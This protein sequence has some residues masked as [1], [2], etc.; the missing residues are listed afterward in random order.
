MK[1]YLRKRSILPDMITWLWALLWFM[2][3]VSKRGTTVVLWLL[4]L[5]VII[6]AIIQKPQI[7]RKQSITGLL[8]LILFLWH[9]NSLLFDP[10]FEEVKAS[11]V[12]KLSLIV[13]PVI[14][15]LGNSSI[16]DSQKWAL[17][18]FYAGL[19]IAGIQM[20]LRA[21]I[22]SF[23]G[24]DLDYWMYHEFATPFQFGAI[25]FSWYLSIA[26]I[27]LIYQRQEP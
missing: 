20:L 9:A 5:C 27:S 8:L 2:L 17:R 15:I 23:Y 1:N 18:G 21:I 6:Q 14:L 7:N 16:K 25:Y 12:R 4:G 22:R 3:P 10:N 19:I 24:F 26:L 13:F 11:L